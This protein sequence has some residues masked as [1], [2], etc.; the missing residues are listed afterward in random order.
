MTVGRN[1]Q[2]KHQ[3]VLD[4]TLNHTNL[5]KIDDKNIYLG[6]LDTTKLMY[7][8]DDDFKEL[9]GNLIDRVLDLGVVK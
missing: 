8:D 5:K 7:I 6:K 4:Y 3:R 2:T 9:L 1:G